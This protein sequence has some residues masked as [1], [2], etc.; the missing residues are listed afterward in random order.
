MILQ[1]IQDNLE[2]SFKGTFRDAMKNG[3]DLDTH[4]VIV[5]WKFFH[6]LL[7]KEQ[8]KELEEGKKEVEEVIKSLSCENCELLRKEIRRLRARLLD[9]WKENER[10]M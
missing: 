10:Q 7:K 6:R 5:D 4:Y 1:E 8:E 2:K 9:C 3:Y